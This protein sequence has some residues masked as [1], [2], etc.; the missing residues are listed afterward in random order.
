MFNKEK[1]TVSQVTKFNFFLNRLE[2]CFKH[3]PGGYESLKDKIQEKTGERN[4]LFGINGLKH[5]LE[6]KIL[7]KDTIIAWRNALTQLSDFEIGANIDLARAI[8]FLTMASGELNH[9]AYVPDNQVSLDKTRNLIEEIFERFDLP[10]FSLPIFELNNLPQ[11]K[12]EALNLL[13]ALQKSLDDYWEL[14]N[15]LGIR[16]FRVGHSMIEHPD[17]EVKAAFNHLSLKCDFI[18]KATEKNNKHHLILG[19]N[20]NR[21]KD[22]RN[23]SYPNPDLLIRTSMPTEG[24]RPGNF[25]QGPQTVFYFTPRS[26]DDFEMNHL[27]PAAAQFAHPLVQSSEHI[28]RKAKL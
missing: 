2:E 26:S 5:V 19:M 13:T 7:D 17:L 11:D 1:K 14:A 27:Y 25:L 21:D 10:A 18:A 9:I 4:R 3:F 20:Y 24:G 22:Q 15:K 23:Q 28:Y 8:G 16:I 12:T 6:L